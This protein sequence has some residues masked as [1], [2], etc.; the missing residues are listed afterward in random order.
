MVDV[1][2][3]RRVSRL[4]EHVLG[5]LFELH[6]PEWRPNRG[7]LIIGALYQLE[8]DYKAYS[9]SLTNELE[10]A[11]AGINSEPVKID[12]SIDFAS[13]HEW[14]WHAGGIYQ[15]ACLAVLMEAFP[16]TYN[17]GVEYVCS[18]TL[19]MEG[20]LSE[21]A[22]FLTDF[23]GRALPTTS[24]CNSVAS[25]LVQ[26]R[27]RAI[28]GLPPGKRVHVPGGA[29]DNSPSTGPQK[30]SPVHI[31]L[32]QHPDSDG[33]GTKEK[34]D[35]VTMYNSKYTNVK[36]FADLKVSQLTQLI[37]DRRKKAKKLSGIGAGN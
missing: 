26:E 11:F 2:V 12:G 16:E 20:E 33:W 4:A 25:R 3:I 9:E 10:E 6:V 18:D 29:T 34:R 21:Y 36:G 17:A 8:S 37:L 22:D 13:A 14:V 28:A 24:V 35:F 15:S 31:L 32:D 23:V 19:P 7:Q 5:C 27:A 30:W 1:N